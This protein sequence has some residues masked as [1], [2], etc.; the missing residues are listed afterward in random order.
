M[1]CNRS[2]PSRARSVPCLHVWAPLLAESGLREAG[3]GGAEPDGAADWPR[4]EEGPAYP[5]I[6]HAK[7]PPGSGTLERCPPRGTPDLCPPSCE[8]AALQNLIMAVADFHFCAADFL[9]KGI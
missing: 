3:R 2:P 6:Q 5:G 9:F 1:L 8:T 7:A 4:P